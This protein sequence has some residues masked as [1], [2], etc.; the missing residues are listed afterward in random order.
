MHEIWWISWS[1]TKM[2]YFWLIHER[3]NTDIHYM[4]NMQ[5]IYKAMKSAGFHGMKSAEFHEI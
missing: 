4:L 2:L 3:S 1:T 5:C